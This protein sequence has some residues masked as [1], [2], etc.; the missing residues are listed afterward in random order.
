MANVPEEVKPEEWEWLIGYFSTDSKFQVLPI[1]SYLGQGLSTYVLIGITFINPLMS[2]KLV[3]RTPTIAKS[4]RQNTGLAQNHM[5][6][7]VMRRYKISIGVHFNNS[8]VYK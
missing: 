6:N 4:K 5:R 7:L 3:K 8:Y 2:R 1:L